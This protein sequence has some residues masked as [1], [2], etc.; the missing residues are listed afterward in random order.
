MK[1]ENFLTMLPHRPRLEELLGVVLQV[2]GHVGAAARLLGGL[3]GELALAV[4]LPARA[5]VP[6]PPACG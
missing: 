6:G 1:S 2:Q 5:V 4:G 3:D